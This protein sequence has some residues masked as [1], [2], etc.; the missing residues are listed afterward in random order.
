[1]PLSQRGSSLDKMSSKRVRLIDGPDGILAV[2]EIKA[3]KQASL[4]RT[5]TDLLFELRVQIVRFE[6]SVRGKLIAARLF[7]V[8]FD[9]A[10]I[11][12][13]RRLQ[14]QTAVLGALEHVGPGLYTRPRNVRRQTEL[15]KPAI[16]RAV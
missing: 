9:G 2:L 13:A 4:F 14:I 10:R 5:I 1:M 16:S 12:A 7:V 11:E 8:E 15:T 3:Y 6:S